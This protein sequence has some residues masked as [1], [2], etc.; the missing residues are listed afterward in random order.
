MSSQD[1]G[2]TAR[3]LLLADALINLI[4]GVLL[5]VYPRPLVL[6]LGF[7][8]IPSTLFSSVLGGVLI[9]IAI[10]LGIASRGG[11]QGLGLDGAIAINI[12][13]AGVVVLR[14]VTAPQEFTTA[15]RTTLWLIAVLVL[16]IGSAE[17][18]HRLRRRNT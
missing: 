13:G 12:C 10:A 6:M 16:G 7:R 14:L 3:L 5:V 8:D 11:R 15:G 2:T 4:L 18:I 1:P 17:L 9:G